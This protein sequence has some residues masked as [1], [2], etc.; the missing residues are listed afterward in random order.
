VTAHNDPIQNVADALGYAFVIPRLLRDALT[1]SSF[2]NERPS[3][4]STDN[5]RLEFMGDAV[6]QWTIS[7]MLW[8]RYP[9][10]TAGEL[11]RRRADLVCEEQLAEIARNLG[12]GAAIRLGKGEERSGG[13]NK[14]RLLASALEACVAAVYLDGS[15]QAATKL[16]HTLFESLLSSEAPGA[17]DFKSRAQEVLQS[18]GQKPPSY[19]LLSSYGPDHARS[20]CV[21][22]VIDGLE[23]ARGE[24][25]TKLEAEQAAAQAFLIHLEE[26]P[27]R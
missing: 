25:R 14:P 23:R 12:I 2:A 21:A 8:D 5:E 11:T 9:Q 6:L 1:H 26:T 19:R 7:S 20:F 27:A 17:R 16:C 15:T 22:V 3:E 4:A 10:A 18:R 13:R 24:G